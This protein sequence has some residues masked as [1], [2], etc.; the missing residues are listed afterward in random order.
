MP[1]SLPP[2]SQTCGEQSFLKASCADCSLKGLCLPIALDMQDIDRIDQV[3]RRGRPLQRGELL[4][5]ANETFG[6]I[7]ALRSGSLKSFMQDEQGMEQ[8]TGFYLPGEIL[9]FDGIGTGRHGNTVVALQTAAVCELPFAHLEELSRQ[10]PMLQHHYF[11]LM[12]RQ[13]EADHKLLLTLSKKSAE[14]RVA[15][16]LVSLSQRFS[17][18]R[19]S[20]HA[21]RLPM[22]R[23]DIGNFLGLTIETVSRTLSRLHREG[24]IAVDGRE[25]RILDQERLRGL[26]H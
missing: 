11:A 25:L 12:S 22:S 15:S 13:I 14:G 26:C 3:I 6:A 21:L 10:I 4:Y 16:L 9:G 8:V 7:Y 19:L 20:P 2:A 1:T 24:V 18:R 17:R 23:Q 5:R